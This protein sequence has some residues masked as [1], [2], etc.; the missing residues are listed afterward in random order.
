M[1]KGALIPE[2]TRRHDG[3]REPMKHSDFEESRLFMVE[4]HLRRRGIS[5]ERVLDAMATVP[6]ELFVP[7]HCMPHAYEDRALGIDEG[8][9][10]SQPWIVAYMTQALDIKPHEKVLE[11]GT[12]SGYQAAILAMLAGEVYSV[13][14]HAPLSEMAALLLKKCGYTTIYLSVGDGTEGLPLHAPYDA[15]MVTAAAP[16]IPE[17]LVEQLAPG[18]RLILPLESEWHET[19]VLV[20]THEHGFDTTRLAECRFV[21]LIGKHGYPQ[22]E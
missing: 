16:R 9:T 17:P 15:I 13:E 10:I 1:E 6:R 4:H 22:E 18:G 12:G 2:V 3:R 5:S 14:R 21:P 20:R 11:I 7:S 8:Q 19:L